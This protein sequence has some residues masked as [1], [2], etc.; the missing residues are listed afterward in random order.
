MKLT[1]IKDEKTIKEILT[2]RKF[3][4]NVRETIEEFINSGA[5][6]AE[7]DNSGYNSAFS[8]TGIFNKRI[9]EDKIGGVKCM[10]HNGKTYIYKTVLEK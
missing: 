5:D 6:M 4:S 9:K 7:I 10:T 2:N 3:Y 8:C 1:P